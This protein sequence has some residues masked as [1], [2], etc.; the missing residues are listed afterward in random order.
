MTT[1]L[2]LLLPGCVMLAGGIA[3]AN[4]VEF[5]DRASWESAVGSFQVEDF[6]TTPLGEITC[7]QPGVFNCPS[8]IIIDA[9]NLDI[10][11][12]P[13][14]DIGAGPFGIVAPGDVNGTREYRADLHSG[15]LVLGVTANTFVLPGLVTSF[16]VDLANVMDYDSFCNVDCGPVPFP[17]TIELG[18]ESFAIAFGSQFFGATSTIPFDWVEVRS[19]SNFQG[20][21]VAASFDN[22]SF[23]VVPEPSTGILLLTGM[24]IV[25]R[26]RRTARSRAA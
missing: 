16:S 11:I 8:T 21:A 15:V 13:N 14:A 5:F 1:I 3:N 25:A 20:L 4:A 2:R 6:E 26:A 18:G 17:L 23:S 10:I 9:P 19:T 7:P 12:P 24:A 22:V